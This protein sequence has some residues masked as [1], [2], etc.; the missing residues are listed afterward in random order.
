LI[1]ACSKPSSFIVD[2]ATSTNNYYFNLAIVAFQ[3]HFTLFFS[4]CFFVGNSVLACSNLGQ[5]LLAL[6]GDQEVFNKVLH[7]LFQNQ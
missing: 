3:F 2:F 5:H 1:G 6:N 4:I 7:P